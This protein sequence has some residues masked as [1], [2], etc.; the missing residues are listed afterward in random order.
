[1]SRRATSRPTSYYIPPPEEFSD[2]NPMSD[3]TS[4]TRCV[5][6][7]TESFEWMI[8]CEKCDK[9]QHCQCM[10]ILSKRA[11][12]EH[13]FCER[14]Q[15]IGHP[16][17][18]FKSRQH[19]NQSKDQ[20]APTKRPRNT[21]NS[22]QTPEAADLPDTFLP[23][24]PEDGAAKAAD[25]TRRRKLNGDVPP[26][27]RVPSPE[28][29]QAESSDHSKKRKPS[30]SDNKN[31]NKKKRTSTD[32]EAVPR[33]PNRM[34]SNDASPAACS[35]PL[36]L[37]KLHDAL[38]A[39]GN[40][41][42]SPGASPASDS[43]LVD[44]S[45]ATQPQRAS[46]RR[47]KPADSRTGGSV[48]AASASSSAKS[49]DAKKK[50]PKPRDK[51]RSNGANG[52]THAAGP[53][54]SHPHHVAGSDSSLGSRHRSSTP[55]IKVRIPSTRSSLSEMTKRAKRLS[56]YI[57]R[58]QVS[59]ASTDDRFSPTD[60]LPFLATQARPSTSSANS[61]SSANSS[62][63]DSIESLQSAESSPS[64]SGGLS[65]DPP[66]EELTSMQVLDQLERCLNKFQ[67]R[68]G[69]IKK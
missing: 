62:G 35:S 45:G 41:S 43:P 46:N 44:G 36:I 65:P 38:D 57:T 32:Q 17:F 69:V 49:V 28:S 47:Y 5:C 63:G 27:K 25:S 20:P 22:N 67:E 1:M 54:S 12:P 29:I 34:G 37:D 15:P 42:P 9:W 6:N 61:V 48:D 33:L 31:P 23:P 13:Y 55:P 3:D 60:R 50:N 58:F 14:C 56:D 30:P 24:P 59:L 16:Y 19:K 68:F 66:I 26:L 51:S 64:A 10:G 11:E 8:Q 2:E 4:E 18:K 21:N 52:S 7:G 40:P 39:D 53:G